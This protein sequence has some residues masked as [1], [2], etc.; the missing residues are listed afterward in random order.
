MYENILFRLGHDSVVWCVR[1]RVCVRIDSL[2]NGTWTEYDTTSSSSISVSYFVGKQ[3]F[4]FIVLSNSNISE[5]FFAQPIQVRTICSEI[6][7]IWRA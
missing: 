4:P 1:V 5:V 6:V 7:D 3:V 2:T